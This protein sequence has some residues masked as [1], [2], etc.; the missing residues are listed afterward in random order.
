MNPLW[1]ESDFVFGDLQTAARFIHRDNPAA[2]HSFLEAAYDTFEFLARNPDVGRQRKDLDFPEI[3]SW[4]VSGFRRY[5][6]FYRAL[7]DRIQ[8]WRVLHGARDLHQTLGGQ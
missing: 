5:L 7:P 2:A 3:R 8:I 4:R 1:E 6:I